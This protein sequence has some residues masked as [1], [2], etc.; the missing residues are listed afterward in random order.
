MYLEDGSISQAGERSD[1]PETALR[2]NGCQCVCMYVCM[3]RVFQK[4][5]TYFRCLL[6][7]SEWDAG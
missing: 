7:P 4:D 3:H 5:L 6:Y 1:L 2:A